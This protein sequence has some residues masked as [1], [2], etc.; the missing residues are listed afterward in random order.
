MNTIITNNSWLKL[1]LAV[2]R[3][4]LSSLEHVFMKYVIFTNSWTHFHQNTLLNTCYDLSAHFLTNQ[5]QHIDSDNSC[6]SH[7]SSKYRNGHKTSSRQGEQKWH[8]I[9][10]RKWRPSVQNKKK[11]G[12]PKLSVMKIFHHIESSKNDLKLYSL[13][14]NVMM[15]I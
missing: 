1:L 3:T 7:D 9:S 5:H 2:N 11:K 12:D 4:Q 8:E 10:E 13:P 15:N 14:S 6:Q